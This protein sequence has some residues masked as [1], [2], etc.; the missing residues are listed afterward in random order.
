[1][2]K[3]TDASDQHTPPRFDERRIRLYWMS[4]SIPL[5]GY[6][7]QIRSFFSTWTPWFTIV[8]YYFW[9]FAYFLCQVLVITISNG[10]LLKIVYSQNVLFI[11]KMVSFST[12]MVTSIKYNLDFRSDQM[13]QTFCQMKGL[14]KVLCVS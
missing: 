1:M 6:L 4:L 11:L 10:L 13:T 7:T 3:K 12:T 2:L 14:K 5:L 8:I 9:D